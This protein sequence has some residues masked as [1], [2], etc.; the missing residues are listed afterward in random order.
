MIDFHTHTLLSDGVLIPSEQVRRASHIGYRAIGLTDHVDGS[1]LE[2]VVPRIAKVAAEL[3][4]YQDVFVVPGAEITHAPPGQI[5][6]LVAEARKLGAIIVIVHGETPSEP[7]AAG[8]NLAGIEAGADILAHPGFITAD[9][10]RLAAQRGVFLEITYR[11][12]HSM[13]NGHVAR[14]AMI[15]GARLVINTDTHSPENMITRETAF[16]VLVGAGLTEAQARAAYKNNEELLEVLK[17]RFAA[18]KK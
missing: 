18:K 2:T 10:A 1:N 8:T 14:I 11:A 12:G 6:E 16:R 17:Q 5:S 13:T 7:V 15:A 4:K 9:E 3:N